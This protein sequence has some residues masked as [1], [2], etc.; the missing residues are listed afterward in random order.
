MRLG[1][2]YWI[3]SCDFLNYIY[4]YDSDINITEEFTGRSSPIGICQL[5]I[6]R[7]R[8]SDPNLDDKE[9]SQVEPRSVK[10]AGYLHRVQM[11]ARSLDFNPPYRSAIQ[12]DKIARPS[13][14]SF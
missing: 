14:S 10:C 6:T 4:K 8:Y 12:S 11:S 13:P 3:I 5:Y 2:K 7:I 1:A 9:Y